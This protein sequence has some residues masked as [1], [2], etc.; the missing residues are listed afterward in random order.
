MLTFILG[1]NNFNMWRLTFPPDIMP[2]FKVA[3]IMCIFLFD[4]V[5]FASAAVAAAILLMENTFDGKCN[6]PQKNAKGER[7]LFGNF[8][9]L[10]KMFFISNLI[11]HRQGEN[12]LSK[13]DQNKIWLYSTQF[14]VCQPRDKDKKKQ[15]QIE[16]KRDMYNETTKFGDKWFKI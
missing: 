1:T 16:R 11:F 15:Q 12:K 5:G 14:C 3:Q 2:I 4:A 6:N 10:E 9:Q 13:F 8:Q 7:V